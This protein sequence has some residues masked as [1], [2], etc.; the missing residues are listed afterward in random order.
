MKKPNFRKK[1][2]LATK[3]MGSTISRSAQLYEVRDDWNKLPEK[4]KN[5]LCG[6]VKLYKEPVLGFSSIDEQAE[7]FSTFK[8]QI[9]K[10]GFF[11]LPLFESENFYQGLFYF[12]RSGCL[13]VV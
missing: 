10:Q 6:G 12:C 9:E 11:F 5:K 8:Q 7:I 3:A 1:I 13:L 4:H 2:F